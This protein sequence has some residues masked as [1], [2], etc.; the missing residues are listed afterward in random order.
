MMRDRLYLVGTATAFMVVLFAAI[1]FPVFRSVVFWLLNVSVC[2]LLLLVTVAIAIFIRF[3]RAVGGPKSLAGTRCPS[4]RKRRAMREASQEFLHGN[5]KFA[6]DH[7]SF[8]VIHR[9]RPPETRDTR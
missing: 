5:A 3:S 7:Y 4:C 9:S 6:L 8:V 2:T 1:L